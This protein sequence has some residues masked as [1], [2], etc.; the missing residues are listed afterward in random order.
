MPKQP[1][2]PEPAQTP[3]WNHENHL[4]F[5]E[6]ELE[7]L[8]ATQR[9]YTYDLPALLNAPREYAP[10]PGVWYVMPKLGHRRDLLMR[11]QFAGRLENFNGDEEEQARCM[12]VAAMPY[13]RVQDGEGSLRPANTQDMYF[14]TFESIDQCMAFLM[15]IAGV[16]EVAG[17]QSPNE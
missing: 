2:Q 5:L 12:L 15:H 14:N 17:T 10:V 16:E 7:K 3:E 13:I 4:K 9:T 6:E 1:P 8:A 11:M